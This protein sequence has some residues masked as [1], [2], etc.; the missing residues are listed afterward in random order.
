[1]NP[2]CRRPRAV[3]VDR[4]QNLY[5]TDRDSN[6]IFVFR[7][8]GEL[9]CFHGSSDLS[10]VKQ[11]RGLCFDQSGMLYLADSGNGRILILD[12]SMRLRGTIVLA[13]HHPMLD[14]LCIFEGNIF[15]S[16]LNN[17]VIYQICAANG[18]LKRVFGG[19]G[20]TIGR[21]QSP[22]GLCVVDN[23]IFVADRDNDRICSFD[24][25]RGDANAYL[26][27]GRG[28]GLVRRP[29]DVK[30]IGNKLYVN[31]CNNYLV[32]V[33]D[34]DFT[35][36]HQFGGKGS[37]PGM[38]DLVSTIA[39]DGTDLYICDRNNDRIIRYD[40][41]SEAIDVVV[42]RSFVPGILSRP[43]GVAVDRHDRI[44]VADRDNDCVQ[45]F[46]SNGKFSKVLP[47]FSRPSSIAVSTLTPHRLWISERGEHRLTLISSD[48]KRINTI[49]SLPNGMR[50]HNPHEVAVDEQGEL[51]VA[52][53][54]NR[55]IHH[56]SICGAYLGT[57][58]M[59]ALSRND[60]VQVRSVCSNQNHLLS[61]DFDRCLVYCL[62]TGGE[63]VLKLD[64]KSLEA[65]IQVLRSVYAVSDQFIVCTRGDFSLYIL[66]SS[67][68][69]LKKFGTRGNGRHQ[70]RN[71]VK[72]LRMHCGDYLVVDKEN[73]R[74]VRYDGSWNFRSEVGSAVV[75]VDALQF[76][77][78][79]GGSD[80]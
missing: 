79:S 49:Q 4:E 61:A 52:D 12:R 45:I 32:Q 56:F 60:H 43:S 7:S 67:G 55:A 16:D 17:H 39:V 44:Y 76:T 24:L 38:L 10:C 69:I 28:S 71:P 36:L 27:S 41:L 1:M 8:T 77:D 57:I 14:S 29:T 19:S 68:E 13:T 46:D 25:S 9:R 35:F 18:E 31:D 11:P 50:I 26:Q 66:S 37:A 40:T 20:N 53:S 23:I 34:R 47:G 73:D 42:A 59:V 48:G 65:S 21:L 22:R 3:A 75:A 2:V 58:E 30:S 80:E 64:L 15:C 54:G 63:S 70:F 78:V 5:V 74:V 51:F 72:V 33:F 62:D 6:G